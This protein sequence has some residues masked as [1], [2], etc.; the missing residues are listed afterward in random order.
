[1]DEQYNNYLAESMNKKHGLRK[2]DIVDVENLLSAVLKGIEEIKKLLEEQ[3]AKKTGKV[4][5]Q[6]DEKGKEEK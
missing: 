4:R 2:K 6:V 3:N 5:K 1:M